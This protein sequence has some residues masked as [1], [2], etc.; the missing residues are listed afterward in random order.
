ML[1]GTSVQ[2]HARG[3][4]DAILSDGATKN[5]Y[6]QSCWP[7]CTRFALDQRR[8]PFPETFRL[9]ATNTMP[10][11]RAG[12]LLGDVFLEVTLPAV[13]GAS[14]S[15]KW[16]PSIGHVILRRVSLKIDETSIHNQERLWYN[17]EDHLFAKSNKTRGLSEMIGASE[18]LPMHV[19]H[20]LYIPLKFFFCKGSKA[21]QQ[22][23]PLLGI[24]GSSIT[25]SIET[26]SFENLTLL[27]DGS[28]A[29]PVQILDARVILEYIHLDA[30]EKERVLRRPHMILYEDVQDVESVSYN[31][32]LDGSGGTKIP[33]DIVTVNMNE[34]NAPVRY[35]TFVSYLASDVSEKRFFQYRSDITKAE[36]LANNVTLVTE[37]E[38]SF[39]KIM[40]KFYHVDS[41]TANQVHVYSFALDASSWQPSGQLGFDQIISPLLKVWL[42]EKREDIVIKAFV[43]TYK[44]LIFDKGRAM[45]KFI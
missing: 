6:T 10:I 9:G 20:I 40:Q 7:R 32:A 2:L 37:R 43:V 26:E 17:L 30:T 38:A 4:Q 19:P 5:P 28:T 44:F 34:V 24:P 12:D 8:E 11:S 15:D 1:Q 3:P 18:Q 36:L 39:Y 13:P 16:V 31:V 23:M 45:L 25:M 42:Q 22:F 14:Q 35:I 29:Q 33:L 41:T 21:R 27:S